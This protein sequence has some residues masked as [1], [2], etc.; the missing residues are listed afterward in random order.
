MILL[1]IWGLLMTKVIIGEIFN[2]KIGTMIVHN[3]QNDKFSIGDKIIFD[4]MDYSIVGIV[5]PSKPDG[6]WSLEVMLI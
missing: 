6:K 3:E 2:T 5:P 1:S 4:N